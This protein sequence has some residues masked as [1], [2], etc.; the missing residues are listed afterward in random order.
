MSAA[1]VTTPNPR[2]ADSIICAPPLDWS[3][4]DFFAEPTRLDC[5]NILYH[6]GPYT[7][8]PLVLL[9][10]HGSGRSTLLAQLSAKSEDNWRVVTVKGLDGLS[11]R[12][13]SAQLAQ[14]FGL[15]AVADD[16]PKAWTAGILAHFRHL[17]RAG[18]HPILLVD[19]ADLLPQSVL[20]LLQSL[21]QEIKLHGELVGL[22]FTA[23]PAFSQNSVCTVL[24]ELGG[25]VFELPPVDEATARK[26]VAHQLK[27]HGLSSNALDERG[28]SAVVRGAHG[29]VAAL[30]AHIARLVPVPIPPM[31]PQSSVTP[32]P[33][34]DEASLVAPTS[35][36]P[37]AGI[38]KVPIKR[39]AT[40]TWL[41][42]GVLLGALLVA[43]AFQDRIN[44]L[45]VPPRDLT[46]SKRP[47]EQVVEVPLG[48]LPPARE[49]ALWIEDAPPAEKAPISPIDVSPAQE[50]IQQR[51][52]ATGQDVG[53]PPAPLNSNSQDVAG[54]TESLTTIPAR[55]PA[56][57]E[58]AEVKAPTVES[59]LVAEVEDMPPA[60]H[61]PAMDPAA[62]LGNSKA[63]GNTISKTLPHTVS[64]PV[65]RPDPPVPALSENQPT[66]AQSTVA[67]RDVTHSP[68]QP[69]PAQT[70]DIH[71][72]AWYLQQSAE[73]FTVQ[74]MAL[75][76]RGIL[77]NIANRVTDGKP[78][79]IYTF[80]RE[81]GLMYALTY[82]HFSSREAAQSASQQLPKELGKVQPW[83][84]KYKIIQQEIRE[85]GNL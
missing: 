11:A 12:D 34:A 8:D 26:L 3:S 84:R 60:V 35:G 81:S 51:A 71:G 53:E 4:A 54:A 85:A 44:E 63:V 5:L 39:R 19:D 48:G 61:N 50:A 9:G 37:K 76:D 13:F 77:Q 58:H 64:E 67:E 14:A 10:A 43:L 46:A 82:G 45:V 57:P 2:S 18:Q 52:S 78:V 72:D 31:P 20:E 65:F 73:K 47:G 62:V 7:N 40:G 80:K 17:T 56:S 75:R 33:S 27:R 79:G 38:T 29:S 24:R 21:A 42:G 41:A 70:D 68:A 36:L 59:I 25:H 30:V 55:L 49:S 16:D 32:A 69:E 22:A 23:L 6:L 1:P 83:V 15:T 66:I 74:I 28:L